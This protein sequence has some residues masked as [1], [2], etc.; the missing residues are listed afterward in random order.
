MPLYRFVTEWEIEAPIERVWEALTDIRSW[1]RWWSYVA[2]VEELGPGDRLGVGS[3]QRFHFNTSLP[4]HLRFSAL[5][6][7]VEPPTCLEGRATGE[8]EGLGRCE[9]AT[10]DGITSVRI[11]WEVK[12]TRWWMVAVSPLAGPYFAWA[13]DLVMARGAQGLAR[14]LNARLATDPP[15]R[16]PVVPLVV[17]AGCAMLVALMIRRRSRPVAVG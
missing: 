10:R 8:L 2:E 9:L 14:Y 13:H 12:P 4:Y 5:I 1:P 17:L 3:L 11:T 16:L 6:T 7:R 15:V